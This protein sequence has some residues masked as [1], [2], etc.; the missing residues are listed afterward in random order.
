MKKINVKEIDENFIDVLSQEWALLSAGNK[1]SLNTMTV[2]WGGIGYLWHKPIAIIFVRPERYTLDYI[3]SN[4]YFTLSFL[5]KE[6]RAIYNYCGKYSGKDVDKVKETG[7]T[8]I[9]TENGSVSFQQARLIVECK[10]L[11]KSRMEESHFIDPSIS[12]WY[13]EKGGLHTVFVG[14]ITNV[15]KQD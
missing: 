1:E 8:P 2:N 12:Q 3:D 13:G 6:H 14:E 5:G 7:L 4:D 10:K 15:W 9:A 11:Y